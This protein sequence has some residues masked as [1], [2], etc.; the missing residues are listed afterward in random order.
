[1]EEPTIKSLQT[2]TVIG[3]KYRG[4]NENQ[5]IPGLWQKLMPRFAEIK[6]RVVPGFSYGLMGN[7]DEVSGEF[8]YLAGFETK[9]TGDPPEG[10]NT[11]IVP[12]QNYAVFSCTLPTLMETFEYIYQT[13]LPG[14]KYERGSG[15]E[16]E[17]YDE[18]FDPQDR[19]SL[20]YL[21]IPVTD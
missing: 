10:M 19:E 7:M 6:E 14:S 2:F 11:W 5:E 1:M 12:A 18:A 20:L 15:P 3:L 4:K 9:V 8:D 17:L 21:Y 16:F 13:W